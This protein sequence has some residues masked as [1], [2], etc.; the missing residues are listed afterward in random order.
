MGGSARPQSQSTV[1]K[2]G[3]VSGHDTVPL[4]KLCQGGPL[5]SVQFTPSPLS[6]I[7]SSAFRVLLL[8]R[9]WPLSLLP[10]ASASAAVSSM[11]WPP[12]R[13]RRGWSVGT[14]RVALESAL[15][16][17]GEVGAR[18]TANVMIRDLDFANDAGRLEVVADNFHGA[19]V[20]DTTL[21]SPLRR[22]GAPR[23]MCWR[24]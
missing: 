13:L 18:V 12:P 6:R 2:W 7:D 16:V 17:C 24:R 20:A 1:C 22:D 10:C 9:L 8:R 5:S 21:V 23:P 4:N 11:P 15:L 19:Q 14:S 3:S